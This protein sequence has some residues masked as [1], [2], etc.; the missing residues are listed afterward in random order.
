RSVAS[1]RRAR[2][3][4][5]PGDRTAQGLRPGLATPAPEPPPP[6]VA[7]VGKQAP[8]TRAA[9]S[10]MRALRDARGALLFATWTT[11]SA[12][13][14]VLFARR[15]GVPFACRLTVS[16]GGAGRLPPS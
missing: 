10:L 14:G 5:T 1:H 7:Q 12:P 15:S 16:K 9:A 13:Q 6:G 11:P 3:R 4:P 8:P 2:P